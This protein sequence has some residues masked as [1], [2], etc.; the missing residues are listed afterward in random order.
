MKKCILCIFI[1]FITIQA[2]SQIVNVEKKRKGN[3]N[4]F[5]GTGGVAFIMK[6]SG[7]K[8][9][10][11]QNSIDI[12]YKYNAN[13]FIFLNNIRFMTIDGGGLENDGFVH[14]RYNYTIKD[15]SFIT[16]EAFGQYQYNENKLLNKRFVGGIG[17][18]FR[19]FNKKSIKW[20]IAPLVMYEYEQLSDSLNTETRLLR[21]DAN[22]SLS[23]SLGKSLSFNHVTYYQPDFGNFNDFR[24]SSETG[25]RFH[26]TKY[27][28]FDMSYAID[29]D[30]DPPPEIQQIFYSFKN[31]LL[32]TF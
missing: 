10:E 4:G 6:E 14:L 28:S 20:F 8:I 29:Y 19:I 30:S 23:I 17:P 26:I 31:K 25:L 9:I 15:S 22:T 13:T 1:I 11:F 12:Q 16:L 5:Q 24:I 2:Q 18:R 27:L 32:I 21:F 7:K 3:K